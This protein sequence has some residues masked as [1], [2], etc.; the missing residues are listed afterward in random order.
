[1][2]ASAPLKLVLGHGPVVL[3][4]HQLLLSLQRRD[5]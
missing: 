2:F 5:L 3:S 1:M 4:L